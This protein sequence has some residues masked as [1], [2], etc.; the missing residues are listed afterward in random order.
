MAEM[1]GVL[2]SFL[3]ALAG[4]AL[5]YFALAGL[6]FMIFWRWGRERFAAHRIQQRVRF[7]EAQ[8]RHEL[9]HT[10]ATLVVGAANAVMLTAMYEAG[11]TK[12]T[13][14]IEHGRELE[15]A[16]IFVGLLLVNDAWFY[17]M[18]RLLHH[19]YLYKKIHIRHHKSV[20]VNPFSSYSFHAV[21]GLL[22]GLWVLPAVLLVPIPLPVVAGLQVIGL[23]NNMMSHLGYELLPRSWVRLPV[24]RWTNTST[25]HNLHHSKMNGNYGLMFRFWD[26]A[27]GTEVQGYE[28]GFRAAREEGAATAEGRDVAA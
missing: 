19:R 10:A 23:A 27:L 9:K 7:D 25:F 4:Q 15:A 12:L 5:G 22:L 1:M 18:H 24:V 13:P 3:G 2:G 6:L 16:A 17:W 21:E 28:E 20:D 14:T 11:W 26:R 8:L